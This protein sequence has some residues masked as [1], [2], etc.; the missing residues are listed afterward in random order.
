MDLPQGTLLYKRYRVERPLGQGGMGAVFLA[1][2]TSLETWV[3]VKVN[4]QTTE[5]SAAQ[6]LREAHLL[7]SLRS[8]NLPRV[9]DYFILDQSQYL[10]MDFIA[11]D[12][13]SGLL[14]QEG[15]QPVEKVL[16]WAHQ[17]GA[18]LTYLHSQ[19]PPVIH[20]DIKPSNIKLTPDGMVILVD[21]GIAKAYD[22]TQATAAG[23]TG[24]T[25]GFAP[26]E[27]YG[28]TGTG[29]FSDQ[30]GLAATLY[31][32][33]TGR[34]PADS[35]LRLLGKATLDSMQSINPKLPVYVEAAVTKA[36]S[37]PPAERFG[38][39]DAFIQALPLNPEPGPALVQ[40]E[41]AAAALSAL[42]IRPLA[43]ATVAVPRPP[44][45]APSAAPAQKKR[46]KG[47]Q[48]VALGLVGVVGVIIVIGGIFLMTRG[49]RGLSQAAIVTAP[50]HTPSLQVV[51]TF[52]AEVT[53]V[54]ALATLLPAMQTAT[55]LVPTKASTPA[56]SAAPTLPAPTAT[57]QALGM[58]GRIAFVSN[59][60]DDKTYQ[61]WTMAVSLSSGGQVTAGDYQQITTGEGN[62]SQPTWSP[63]GRRLLFVAPG[64]K[65]GGKELGLDI[66]VMDFPGG[67]PVDLTR[68]VGDERDPAWSPD[69]KLI[70][71]SNDG[72]ED[73]IRQL[74]LMNIDGSDQSKV[75]DQFIESM[76]T[77]SPDMKWLAYVVSGNG[78]PFLYLRQN[79]AGFST[80]E[81]FD[82]FSVTG[83]LGQVAQPAWS[84]D[85]NQIA[86]VRTDGGH[87][88][89]WSVIY[90]SGGSNLSQLSK[91]PGDQNPAWSPDSHWILYSSSI[92]GK[93]DLFLMTAAGT[94]QTDLTNSLS[95][96]LQPAW[97]PLPGE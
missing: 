92:N 80:P 51:A 83:R 5:E 71:F 93:G 77:W 10:V 85:G 84:P 2:D 54:V 33:L 62:K 79:V 30:F 50:T 11:G 22:P 46:L 82:H 49:M 75:S 26:P 28:G 36:L 34:P 47:W 74:F 43:E 7:A 39:V 15:A 38:S 42:T 4:R 88:Q 86:Y 59:Q 57:H 21:F 19:N 72:R 9:I 97:Q 32:M 52:P 16:S 91:G 94:A 60:A 96:E 61:I 25:P 81:P 6:F 63:D 1:F 69:G 73:K 8:P 48:A 95:D 89:I 13:L 37:I 66:W 68:R 40:V 55:E 44:E 65:E 58:G 12:D 67:T 20:R 17:L 35:I 64:G 3:A 27:Q 24:Y 87:K 14:R 53:E 31:A 41:P 90:A 76:P 18:A 56:P 70:V 45:T 78:F 23:A 29:P